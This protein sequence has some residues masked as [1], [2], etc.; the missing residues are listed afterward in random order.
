MSDNSATLCL[1][2]PVVISLGSRA[3]CGEL[4]L[5]AHAREVRVCVADIAD[6]AAARREARKCAECDIAS[7]NLECVAMTSGDLLRVIDWVRSR[8]LLQQL[9]I[10]ILAPSSAT[11]AALKAAHHRPA[12]VSRVLVR[13]AQTQQPKH[14]VRHLTLAY[15]A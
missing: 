8:R 13:N 11:R 10:S 14:R 12:S 1:H 6:P 4:A 15:S 7:L 2:I 5:P 3:L 9:P